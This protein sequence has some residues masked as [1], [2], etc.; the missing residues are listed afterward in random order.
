ML[1]LFIVEEAAVTL[2]NSTRDVQRF[3][4]SGS[5]SLSGFRHNHREALALSCWTASLTV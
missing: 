4:T 2:V 3:V 1:S 5:P